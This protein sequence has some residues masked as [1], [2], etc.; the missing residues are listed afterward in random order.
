MNVEPVKVALLQGGH[1]DI[2]GAENAPFGI[3]FKTDKTAVPDIIHLNAVS[4]IVAA[5]I[6]SVDG[7]IFE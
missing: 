3:S 1:I 6:G 5:G 2:V 4:I 7:D